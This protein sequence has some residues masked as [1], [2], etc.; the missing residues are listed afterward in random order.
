MMVQITQ[1]W[2]AQPDS[3][4]TVAAFALDNAGCGARHMASTSS[5]NSYLL[6]HLILS[7]RGRELPGRAA[8]SIYTKSRPRG[9]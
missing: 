2:I 1:P 9:M 7:F 4:H 6:P 8:P 5:R 3:D